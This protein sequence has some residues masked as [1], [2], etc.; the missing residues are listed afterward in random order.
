MV[1]NDN[2]IIFVWTTV[3]VRLRG[4]LSSPPPPGVNMSTTQSKHTIF[5]LFTDFVYD[6]VDF[7]LFGSSCQIRG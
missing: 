6:A 5:F 7:E 3:A 1:F 4:Y 2:V